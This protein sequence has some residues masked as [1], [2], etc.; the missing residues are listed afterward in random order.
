[1]CVCV[2]VSSRSRGPWTRRQPHLGLRAV[3]RMG[4]QQVLLRLL[5]AR[6]HHRVAQGHPGGDGGAGQGPRCDHI[7]FISSSLEPASAQG[8]CLFNVKGRVFLCRCHP[9]ALLSVRADGQE[10]ADVQSALR[11]LCYVAP[12]QGWAIYGPW[13]TSG[14][15]HA[16][17]RPAWNQSYVY[18]YTL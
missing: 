4:W 8:F 1:M 17:V 11:E 18:V 2:C 9:G 5:T 3:A 16:S 6:R 13:A 7:V 10:L 14:Q 15:L 12:D